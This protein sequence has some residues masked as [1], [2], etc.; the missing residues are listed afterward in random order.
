[1][2][3]IATDGIA[4]VSAKFNGEL[5]T[6]AGLLSGSDLGAPIA[7]TPRTVSWKGK[8][9]LGWQGLNA[10]EATVFTNDN[11]NNASDDDFTLTITFGD[12][13]TLVAEDIALFTRSTSGTETGTIT[14]DAEIADGED[15]LVT[16][17]TSLTVGSG[18]AVDANLRGI[19]GQQGVLA[20]FATDGAGDDDRG[21]GSYAGGFVVVSNCD[22]DPFNPSL[23]CSEAQKN[24]FCALDGNAW[25]ITRC[26]PR[27]GTLILAARARVADAC[28]ADL[29]RT[30]SECGVMI[31]IDGTTIGDCANNPYQ[32]A[33]ANAGFNNIRSARVTYCSGLGSDATR[34]NLVQTDSLCNNDGTIDAI[35]AVC[36]EGYIGE[37][38]VMVVANP[39]A[40][41]CGLDYAVKRGLACTKLTAGER[42]AKPTCGTSISGDILAYCLTD[43][44]GMDEANC[45]ASAGEGGDIACFATPFDSSCDNSN[46]DEIRKA[47]CIENPSTDTTDCPAL[48]TTYCNDTTANFG[49]NPFHDT[50]VK[51]RLSDATRE[52]LCDDTPD[53][54]NR[55]PDVVT[56]AC[57]GQQGE[58]TTT[59]NPFNKLCYDG[60]TYKTD[61][62]TLAGI[63]NDNDTL[64]TDPR[65]ILD[66]TVSAICADTGTYANLYAVLCTGREN[67][68]ELRH[69][70]CLKDA[71][72]HAHCNGV[73]GILETA[74]VDSNV[75]QYGALLDDN[76][77]PDNPS[78]DTRL[79]PILTEPTAD[80]PTAN[81]LLGGAT[82]TDLQDGV[83]D[84]VNPIETLNL[85]TGGGDNTP[86]GGLD[87]DGVFVFNATIDVDG[88]DVNKL[89]AGLLPD[90]NLGAT[91][92]EPA[93]GAPTT[94]VWIGRAIVQTFAGAGDAAELYTADNF[95]L[96]IDFTDSTVDSTTEVSLDTDTAT[97][98]TLVASGKFS[99]LGVIFG[100]TTLTLAGG[101]TD[102]G[103]LT[104]L[105]AT[106][107][108]LG[109][110]HSGT[111]AADTGLR[112]RVC[113]LCRNLH[114]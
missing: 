50:C 69:I 56:L 51:H 40:V 101:S 10:T 2:A 95:A 28:N 58:N 81:F 1:M 80:D 107:G 4:I 52:E 49:L 12:V 73:A 113:R 32:T 34:L 3:G 17:T 86:L 70:Q 55:C 79:T 33:C 38:G 54:S 78:D 108:A 114:Q 53:I 61:R 48:I 27:T 37:N 65:C 41:I 24:T 47:R 46:F 90:V 60:D 88:S 35:D 29:T 94:A 100:T 74:Q 19:I 93:Q 6:Y 62:E 45:G 96:A 8:I 71:S 91:L 22:E 57:T 21:F 75:W 20:V 82:Q 14:I 105:I 77:T 104:G 39:F 68:A 25:D 85:A 67:I 102:S 42:A 92:A 109:A 23:S 15:K 7:T 99:K 44:G 11:P 13:T 5:Q 97:V 89:Y 30:T 9:A 64:P 106:K 26:L 72:P 31:M 111:T 36:D 59:A 18:T 63:C 110:F 103:L 112:G 84:T 87:T 76:G 98:A 83:L 16:G 66:D 43:A